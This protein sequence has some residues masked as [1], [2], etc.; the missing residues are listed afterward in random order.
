MVVVLF[1]IIFWVDD[2]PNSK[3]QSTFLVSLPTKLPSRTLWWF[4]KGWIVI[5]SPQTIFFFSSMSFN[6]GSRAVALQ[7]LV[8][9]ILWILGFSSFSFTPNI[10]F[11]SAWEFG[12]VRNMALTGRFFKIFIS[13]FL[14]LESMIISICDKSIL[15]KD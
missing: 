1:G 15:V 2:L 12:C 5:I 13:S 8:E 4:N 9:M 11:I 14:P 7:E 10:T 3:L 6:A